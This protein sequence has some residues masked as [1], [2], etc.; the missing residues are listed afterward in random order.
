[1]TSKQ[2]PTQ[3]LY[4]ITPELKSTR[5]LI[6]SVEKVID[7]GATVIQ[8]RD[9]KN[10]LSNRLKISETLLTLCHKR[11][12]P[13]IIN[14][15][16]ALAI[17]IGADGVHLGKNDCNLNAARA[18][19][20]STAIIGV[21]CY[22]L[23]EKAIEAE[24]K[25]ANYVAFGRFFPSQSKPTATAVELTTLEQAKALL[26]IPIVAIG[27][28]TTENGQS[29]IT[30]GADLLAVIHSLFKNGCPKKAAQRF[31]ALF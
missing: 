16:I 15:D 2:F 10:N 12:I 6:L 13:L 28:I 23:L 18:Q 3:G 9:K 24:S 26:S 30:A 7:G 22:N 17:K 1:M 29:L 27:G 31:K 4:A 14:D 25:G 8:Y 5:E 11:G 19:L 21:S 20:G